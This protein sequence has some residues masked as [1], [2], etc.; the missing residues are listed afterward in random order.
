MSPSSDSRRIEDK[1]E[2]NIYDQNIFP[3]DIEFPRWKWHKILKWDL[4]FRNFRLTALF[5][6]WKTNGDIFSTLRREYYETRVTT[7]A[8]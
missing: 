3:F 7:V 1:R 6:V 2:K 8:L 4:K 5:V